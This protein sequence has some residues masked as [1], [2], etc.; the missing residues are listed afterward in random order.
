[1]RRGR[2][3]VRVK[4][5]MSLDGRTALANGASQWITGAAARSDVQQWRAR[6]SAILTGIGT[7]LAD[8]PR[9]DVRE[10]AP[11]RQPLRVVLDSRLRTPPEARVLKKPGDALVFTAIDDSQRSGALERQGARVERL[12]QERIDLD[13]VL[14][15]LA[16]LQMN[17][18]L[19]EAGPRLAGAFVRA[20]LADELLLYIAPLLLGHTA[21]PLMELPE[22]ADLK[23]ASRF[24]MMDAR[25]MGDDLRLLLRPR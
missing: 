10:G 21:R 9:L 12:A 16:A 11:Q 4:L 3:W 15:R 7:I 6:S 19:V 8:D 14:A 24:T 5:G 2:P 23:N 17:D 18:I 22:L 13:A 20:S 25:A 1:M